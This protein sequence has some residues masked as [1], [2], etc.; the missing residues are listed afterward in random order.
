[1]SAE[2]MPT[3]AQIRESFI[4][5]QLAVR[6][7]PIGTIGTEYPAEFDRWHAEEVRKAKASAWDEGCAAGWDDRESFV[8]CGAIPS[9]IHQSDATNPYR[10]TTP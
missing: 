3:T 5:A 9:G 2:Y 6:N 4:Y 1:M 8:H 7:K 10:E